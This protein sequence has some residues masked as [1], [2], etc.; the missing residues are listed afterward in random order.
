MKNKKILIALAIAALSLTFYF[1]CG[2]SDDAKKSDK[3]LF[4]DTVPNKESSRSGDAPADDSSDTDTFSEDKKREEEKHTSQKEDTVTFYLTGDSR[5]CHYKAV[6]SFRKVSASSDV[7]GYVANFAENIS[8]INVSNISSYR[9]LISFMVPLDVTPGTY[10]EKSSNFIVQFFGT[11][12]GANYTLDQAH[13]FSMTI[14]EWGGPGGRARGQ[15]S[16]ELKA[17]EST[18]PVSIRDGMFDIAIQD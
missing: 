12:G 15:F 16:G 8:G 13:T 1:I 10:T 18:T 17:E 9:N 7:T 6:N 11:E 2:K 5:Q 14:T 3:S 4:S